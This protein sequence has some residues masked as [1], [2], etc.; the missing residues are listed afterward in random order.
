MRARATT[1]GLRVGPPSAARAGRTIGKHDARGSSKGSSS[2]ALSGP[3]PVACLSDLPCSPD[4][5]AASDDGFGCPLSASIKRSNR[6]HKQYTSI[7]PHA[8]ASG[9]SLQSDEAS[10]ESR[11]SAPL[12]VALALSDASSRVLCLRYEAAV[13]LEWQ[14]T[15]AARSDTWLVSGGSSATS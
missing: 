9:N 3:L 1:A 4:G 6:V 5:A 11:P 10:P 7:C 8:T 15:I 13:L 2:S 12:A 14:H